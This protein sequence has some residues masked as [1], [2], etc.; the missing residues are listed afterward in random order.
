MRAVAAGLDVSD[1]KSLAAEVDLTR[2]AARPDD[3]SG[4]PVCIKSCRALQIVS[5]SGP[6]VHSQQK[7]GEVDLFSL[8][9]TAT[10]I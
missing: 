8:D 2:S 4:Q 6:D 1:R 10:V 7:R 3:R 9:I 5:I